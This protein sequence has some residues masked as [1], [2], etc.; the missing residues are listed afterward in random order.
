MK[1]LFIIKSAF[2]IAATLYSTSAFSQKKKAEKTKAIEGKKFDVLFYEVK[3]SGRGKAM[4]SFIEIRKGGVICDLMEDKISFP[5]TTSYEITLD[6][7]Y[8]EEDSEGRIISFESHIAEGKIDFKWEAT[9]T[10]YEIEGMATQS[11][12]GIE[13][14]RF[15]FSGS[16]KTKKK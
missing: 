1:K 8:T 6:S 3:A 12:D 16:E 15:E 7:S 2:L 10:N 4:Q 14:K 9:I 13:K 5:P 11:K